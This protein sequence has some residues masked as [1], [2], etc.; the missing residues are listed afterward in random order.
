MK[1]DTFLQSLT[2]LQNIELPFLVSHEKMAPFERINQLRSLD[3]S[4]LDYREAAVLILFYQK[5]NETYFV[6]TERN[7]YAGVHSKQ[8]SLPGG[9]KEKFDLDL[10]HTAVRETE[11]EIGINI[12]VQQVASALSPVYVPPSNFMIYPFIGFANQSFTFNPDPREVKNIIEVKV[13]DLFHP[14]VVQFQ[15]MTTSYSNSTSVPY[16]KINDYVVWGATAMILS[17]LIDVLDVLLKQ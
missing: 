6:L 3:F 5:N 10:K 8:I 13:A 7:E 15:N 12:S 17:E 2:K 16:F 11:E 4:S 14:D 9:K 1:F